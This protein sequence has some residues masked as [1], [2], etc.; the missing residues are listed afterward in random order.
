MRRQPLLVIAIA[1][2]A[3][4]GPA[5]AP[6]A[7]KFPSKIVKVVVAWPAGGFVDVI[8]RALTEKLS[9]DWANP[10]IVEARPGAYGLIGTELVAKSAA[11]G[12]TWLIGTLGTPM[13]SSLY[14]KPW[15]AVDEFAGVAM[16]AIAPVIAVV[17]AALPLNSLKELVA[18]ARTQPG[19]LNYLNPSIGSASHLNTELVKLKERIDIVSV[20]YNGQPPGVPDLLSGR[21]Q[22]ALLAPVLAAPHIRSGKLKAVAVGFPDRLPEFPDVPTFAQAGYPEAD[23]V[24]SYSILVPKQ[25]PRDIVVR[26]S[27]GVQKAI[28]DPG[29]RKRIE[30]AGAF[31]A[32]PSTPEQVDAFLKAETTRWTA[33]FRE[34]KPDSKETAAK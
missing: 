3:V 16:L 31:V 24:A 21:L 26:I 28:T 1:L 5:A 19:K 13:S 17:P 29:V 10:I 12:H 9:A 2:A 15:H 30:G 27:A 4:L 32:A 20:S 34:H 33:F 22:F 6:A 8:T 11:D 14:G 25:T 7:D 23:V 18:L